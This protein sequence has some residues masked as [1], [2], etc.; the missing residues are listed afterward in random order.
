MNIKMLGN[1][2]TMIRENLGDGVLAVDIYS[3][4]DGQPL[5]S[6]NSSATASALFSQITEYMAGA[7]S[8]SGFPSMG[9]FYIIDLAD[10]KMVVVVPL[11]DYQMGMLVDKT[12][13]KMGLLM[14][15]VIPKVVD[16]F[17]EAL[18]SGE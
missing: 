12:K 17:E 4:D 18:I 2:I 7:L 3:G 8:A 14:S 16:S 1:C 15:I 11:G 5:V 6:H 13:V 10:D 9:S